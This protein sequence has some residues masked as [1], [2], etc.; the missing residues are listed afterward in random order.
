M[1][2][3][4]LSNLRKAKAGAVLSPL[5]KANQLLSVSHIINI[6]NVESK[7]IKLYSSIRTAARELEVNHVTLLNYINKEKLFKGKY[8]IKRNC[9]KKKLCFFAKNG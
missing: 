4:A 3:K 5:A 1:S 8:M 7:D 9:K 6:E 2:E